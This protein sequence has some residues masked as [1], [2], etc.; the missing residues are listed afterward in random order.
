MN[1]RIP[2]PILAAAALAALLAGCTS[3]LPN[4]V[5]SGL[6]T[7]VVDSVLVPL[8]AQNIAAHSQLDV[9]DDNANRP[10]VDHDVLYL[11]SQRGTGS[12]IL[13]NF[14]FSNPALT[15]N[16][17]V[18]LD[19]VVPGNIVS[20]RLR[21]NML[22]FY[23]TVPRPDGSG[24][25]GLRKFYQIYR[26]D[27]PFDT[28]ATWPGPIPPHSATLLNASTEP[29]LGESFIVNIAVPADSLAA[30]LR[31]QRR[32]G[33]L[34]QEGPAAADVDTGMVGF[35]SRENRF[36][37]STIKPPTGTVTVRK[38]GP[39]FRCKFAAEGLEWSMGSEADVST[40]HQIAPTP[41]IDDF[42]MLRTVIRS[43][44]AL[45]FD[46]SKLPANAYINRAVLVVH[47]DSINGYGNLQNLVVS[48]MDTTAFGSP[49]RRISLTT[50]D[51]AVDFT[52][53]RISSAD[54]GY[55]QR[56]DFNVTQT[57]QRYVNGAFT[58]VRG[59]VLTGGESFLGDTAVMGPGYWLSQFEFYGTAAGDSL[60]PRLEITYSLHG[61]GGSDHE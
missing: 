41:P 16:D 32:I 17:S 20:P 34:I 31:D 37:A 14:D 10:F 2:G 58:G 9:V 22:D 28:T 13:V 11:G 33:Y 29:D 55:H 56:F 18:N 36:P 27:A 40:F 59:L 6:A 15:D 21:L 3:D 51:A 1:L 57:I 44:P 61:A 39:T 46:L 42:L 52:T 23:T 19:M 50:L 48:E 30:W 35:S 4:E 54:P 26:L 24:A 53:T 49:G 47:N 12:A 38:I 25:I 7:V 45:Y 43:Y 5:G 60:R 8:R